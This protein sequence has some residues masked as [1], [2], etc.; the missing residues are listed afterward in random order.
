MLLC[1]IF[2]AFWLWLAVSII[3]RFSEVNQ[4][5]LADRHVRYLVEPAKYKFYNTP[6]TFSGN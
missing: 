5:R 3:G 4:R 1:L 6:L 2:K